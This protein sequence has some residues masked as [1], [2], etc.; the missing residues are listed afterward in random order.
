MQAVI[1]PVCCGSGKYKEQPSTTAPV[2]KQCHGCSGRGWVE[3][4]SVQPSPWP[5]PEPYYT[6]YPPT[7]Y[8]YPNPYYHF[9]WHTTGIPVNIT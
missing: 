1:C 9:Q 2:E 6:Y 4:G 7:P 8:P 5:I 3:I